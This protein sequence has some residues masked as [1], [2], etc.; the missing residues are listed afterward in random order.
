MDRNKNIVPVKIQSTNLFGCCVAF[1]WGIYGKIIKQIA[2]EEMNTTEVF[3][4][5]G[6]E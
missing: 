6:A 2:A 1:I 3:E 4:N 5:G